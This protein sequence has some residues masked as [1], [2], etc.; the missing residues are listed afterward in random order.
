[1]TPL[2][3]AAPVL[4]VFASIQGEGHYVGEPQVFLRLAGCPMRCAWCDTPGSWTVT[5]GRRARISRAHPL[6]EMRMPAGS[7]EL[8][9]RDASSTTPTAA[10]VQREDQW[11]TPFQAAVWVA[12]AEPGEPRTVSVTGGEPLLW[13]DFLRALR[14]MLGPRRLHLE[15]GGGH[16]E[17]LARVL[18]AF[19]HVSLDL[20]LPA[21][22]GPPVELG[23]HVAGPEIQPPTSEPAPR[24]AEEWALA[25]RRALQ[26]LAGR[27]A[28]AKVVVAAGRAPRE[29]EPLFEDVAR[30]AP[31]L[32][33][34]LSPATPMHGVEAPAL[35]D[36][37]EVVE[38]ARELGLTT[39]VVPQVHRFLRIP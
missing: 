36:L 22:M 16:P 27:D 10:N 28:C 17:T 9:G 32:P 18:E 25:R 31:K 7:P 11:A 6:A 8:A 26:L 34:Y 14:T 23:A 33:V 15:T 5:A 2:E 35:D 29:F 39:R 3:V 37:V 4:E 19:D 20:K 12:S 30:L 13:P 24:D 38:L 21:D 1:V